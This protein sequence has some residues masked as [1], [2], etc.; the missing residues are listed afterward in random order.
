MLRLL[1]IILLALAAFCLRSW[2]DPCGDPITYRLGEVDSRFGMTAAELRTT[3]RRAEA[4]WED[5]V[6]KDLF[7]Y[8][9]DGKLVVNLVYDERQVTTQENVRRENVI[10]STGSS[11]VELREKYKSASAKYD[12]VRADYL[13]EQAAYEAGLAAHNSDVARW[14]SR[15]DLSR[16]QYEA[17]QKETAALDSL[18]AALEEKR[19]EVNSLA[20]RANALSSQYNEAAAEVNANIDAINTTAGREFKQGLYVQDAN[21]KRIDVF[22]FIGPNDLVHVLA[23]ELGHAI[24]LLHDED[25]DS[26]MYGLNST[27]AVVLSG[28]DIAALRKNCRF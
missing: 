15:G 28:G 7:R 21:G 11:A 10:S 20:S 2:A 3:L 23:H 5:P 13:A 27:E 16:S 26:I 9:D 25:P 24:G 4:V 18:Q 17:L 12:A 22:T 8:A 19:L 14:N 6:R 1:L